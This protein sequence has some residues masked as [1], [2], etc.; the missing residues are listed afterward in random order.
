LDV[1]REAGLGIAFNATPELSEVADAVIR[2]KDLRMLLD[3][4]E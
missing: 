3:I 1:V 2:K 4:L